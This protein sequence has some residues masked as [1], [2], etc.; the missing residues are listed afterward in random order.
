VSSLEAK[1]KGTGQPSSGTGRVS[2]PFAPSSRELPVAAKAQ[3]PGELS[4]ADEAWLRMDRAENHMVVTAVMIT[5]TPMTRARLEALLV[6][7]LLRHPRFVAAPVRSG[8]A[9]R[10]FSAHRPDFRPKLPGRSAAG[11][12]VGVD[13]ARSAGRGSAGYLCFSYVPMSSAVASTWPTIAFSRS[14]L[15]AFAPSLGSTTSSA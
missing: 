7:K 15:V 5:E 6:Q 10:G 12:S 3:E 14:A 4:A 13:R 11:L 9:L 2:V 8:K 1:P